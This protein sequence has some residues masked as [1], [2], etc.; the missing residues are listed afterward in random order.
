MPV[1]E[2]KNLHM[3]SLA[4]GFLIFD[5][6]QGP[7]CFDL[8]TSG[9]LHGLMVKLYYFLFNHYFSRGFSVHEEAYYKNVGLKSHS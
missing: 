2:S 5:F 9:K 7:P 3:K 1:Y 4:F 6:D 8:L